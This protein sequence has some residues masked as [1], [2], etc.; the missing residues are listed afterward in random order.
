MKLQK[1]ILLFAFLC[2]SAFVSA[3]DYSR[4]SD[5]ELSDQYAKEIDQIQIDIKQIKVDLKQAKFS[6]K[7]GQNA[8]ESS[9][10]VKQRL[11]QKQNDLKEVKKKNSGV[12]DSEAIISSIEEELNNI[13]GT[14]NRTISL[15]ESDQQIQYCINGRDLSQINGKGSKKNSTEARFPKLMNQY[16][17]MI[18][19]AAL[20]KAQDNYNKK[21]NEAIA[22]AT[23]S[24][25]VDVAQYMCQKIATAGTTSSSDKGIMEQTPLT[26]PYAISY[27]VGAGLST[28][29]LIKGGAGATNGGNS[30]LGGVGANASVY[31]TSTFD[32][33]SRTCHVCRTITTQSCSKS[34][35]GLFSSSS[36]SCESKTTDPA[37]EDVK[38]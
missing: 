16:R 2:V 36:Y 19:M 6:E 12:K 3:Q 5:K 9:F 15:V 37:C 29:D 23:K 26:A 25:S 34:G 4:M 31:V 33:E 17:V 30:S 38:M 20:R 8:G 27:D 21:V 35:G 28:N 11:K 1:S 13:A 18:G 10:A 22:E 7:H 14:I 24:A 32:R